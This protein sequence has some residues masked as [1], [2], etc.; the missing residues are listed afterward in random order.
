MKHQPPN[1][2]TLIA[3]LL[4]AST[5]ATYFIITAIEKI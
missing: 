2:K 1:T 4:L 3:F 5:L